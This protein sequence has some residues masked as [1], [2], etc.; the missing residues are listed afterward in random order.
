MLVIIVVLCFQTTDA[1]DCEDAQPESSSL[2]CED[3][4][5]Y[6]LCYDLEAYQC[7]KSCRKCGVQFTHLSLQWNR[8]FWME[9]LHKKS[10]NVTSCQ[11]DD[12]SGIYCETECEECNKSLYEEQN[13]GRAIKNFD[14]QMLLTL[15]IGL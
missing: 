4:A 7:Q 12:I 14:R 6:G 11:S 15:V 2:S 9:Q 10:S 5:K 13:P 3:H 1:V 8:Q